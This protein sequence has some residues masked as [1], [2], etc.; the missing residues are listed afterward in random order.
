MTTPHSPSLEAVLAM[1]L[2]LAAAAL[3]A[4]M[5]AAGQS[6]AAQASGAP[7]V[8]TGDVLRPGDVVRLAV[9]REESF[10]G[11]FVVD[12]DG[13]VVLPR[14]GVLEVTG[15]P[16]AELRARILTGL[17]R[18]LRNP[19]IEVVFLRRVAIHG[20]VTHAGLYPVD[21]TMTVLDALAL[22]GGARPD[23]RLDQ[24]RLIR[25]GVEVATVPTTGLQLE[26]LRIRS[27]DQLFVPEQT[28]LRRNSNLVVTGISSVASLVIAILY[29]SR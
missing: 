16:T 18:Y 12:R 6:A 10:S 15:V 29:L 3:T 14:L 9:W 27:G 22:A 13:Q 1:I 5:P 7:A 11:Q 28:W 4:P 21:P 26:E 23:G 25:D 17:A 20:A 2:F 24:I 8:D 19:S